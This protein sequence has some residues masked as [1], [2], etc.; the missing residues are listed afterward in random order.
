MAAKRA[1]A[2]KGKPQAD[3]PRIAWAEDS[4][5]DQILIKESLDGVMADVAFAADGLHLLD[6]VQDR[7]PDLVVLDLR[8]PRLGGLE[9]LRRLRAEPRTRE[10]PVCVFSA[11]DQPDEVAAC[12]ALGALEVLQKP[13]DFDQ[14]RKAVR[15]ITSRVA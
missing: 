9:T 8:M 12:R 15:R 4:L 1:G 11:G 5:H 14:Y 6:A 7:T 13:V 10:L 2:T 3:R